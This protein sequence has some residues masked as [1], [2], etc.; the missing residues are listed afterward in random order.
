MADYEK[1]SPLPYTS[2][3]VDKNGV[4][5]QQAVSF[6]ETIANRALII[7]SGSPEGA[8]SALKGSEYMDETG[9]TGNIKWI[10]KF[11]DVCGDS[12][13]GWILQ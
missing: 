8:V 4:L 11:N 9:T 3:V 10:K 12:S 1:I 7:G 5:T 13:L 2:P 6:F